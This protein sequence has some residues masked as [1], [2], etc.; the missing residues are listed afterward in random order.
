MDG[1]FLM[2]NQE[3]R[4][5]AEQ[6]R[7]CIIDGVGTTPVS[8]KWPIWFWKAS[9]FIYMATNEKSSVSFSPFTKVT[10]YCRHYSSPGP[11]ITSFGIRNVRPK[12]CYQLGWCHLFGLHLLT[13]AILQQYR[14][15]SFV[16]VSSGVERH[17][18]SEKVGTCRGDDSDT[19]WKRKKQQH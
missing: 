7:D 11:P 13:A 17:L 10:P 1:Q 6:H 5:Q 8:N 3:T 12:L 19:E 9:P 18:D 14:P 16:S 15:Q 4:Q 2:I